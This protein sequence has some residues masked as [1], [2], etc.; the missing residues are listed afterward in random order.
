MNSKFKPELFWVKV[1]KS[2]GCWNWAASL[3]KAGY[4]MFRIDRVTHYAH[5]I[6]YELSF[7]EI[8][9][10]MVIC[11]RCDNR[12]CLNPEHLFV[13]TQKE[14]MLDKMQKGRGTDFRYVDE[15]VSSRVIVPEEDSF[16][17]RVDKSGDCWEWTGAKKPAGYGAFNANGVS[18][19]AHRYSYALA[20]GPIAPGM[21][22][23]HSC[24]NPSC[25]NPAHLSLGTPKENT[26]DMIS[27]KRDKNS[28]KT[29]CDHGHEFSPE[30]TSI[31]S[32][33]ARHCKACIKIRNTAF[34]EAELV[35]AKN[36][37]MGIRNYRLY[38]RQARSLAP[39]A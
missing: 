18:H 15:W 2:D 21:F 4:G 35:E 6:S 22:V 13:A 24:D 7:G 27:K 25:V 12:R 14:N 9:D 38:K 29:R 20:S 1:K 32:N 31:G 17:A 23:M 16:W 36:A 34:Y 11:H 39:N 26:R 10:G 33:G 37:G 30:N 3:S 28:R 8:P 5:R 19:N